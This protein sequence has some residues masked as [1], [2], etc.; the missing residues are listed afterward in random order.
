MAS[1]HQDGGSG[2]I[3]CSVG[4]FWGSC[5]GQE[6]VLFPGSPLGSA[7]VQGVSVAPRGCPA[8][9]F[10]IAEKW[11]SVS[12]RT[13]N[14]QAQ[15]WGVRDAGMGPGFHGAL[16]GATCCIQGQV[17][18]AGISLDSTQTASN[19]LLYLLDFHEVSHLSKDSP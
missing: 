8:Q 5:V 19:S 12:L 6:C 17:Q 3:L 4:T 7:S 10:T 16:S 1:L 14:R 9:A 2:C 13:Q 11:C 18:W 15:Y